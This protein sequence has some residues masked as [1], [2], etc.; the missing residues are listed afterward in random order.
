MKHIWIGFAMV[1]V[2]LA[3]GGW[4]WLRDATDMPFS[5][6]ESEQPADPD[7][8]AVMESVRQEQAE[9]LAEAAA[10]APATPQTED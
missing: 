6:T 10:T 7:M 2:A 1:A 4:L 8:E 3:I 5:M 9:A